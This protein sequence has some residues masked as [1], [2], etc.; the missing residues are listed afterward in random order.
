MSLSIGPGINIVGSVIITPAIGTTIP[1][2]PIIGIAL[3]NVPTSANVPYTAPSDN[4]GSTILKYIATS[5]PGGLTGTLNQAGSGTITV[6]GLTPAT[7]Y[8]FRVTATNSI[9]ISSPSLPSNI[10]STPGAGPLNTVAP[11]VTGTATVG[12]T[13]STDNGTWT[14]TP[15]IVFTYQWQRNSA[16][17]SSATNNTYVLVDADAENPIRCVVTGTNSAGTNLANSNAT[18]NVSPIAPGAPTIGTA[19][20]IT[21]SATVDFT[22]PVNNGGS[23]ILSYTA[24]SSPGGLTGTV[25]QSGSGTITVTGLTIDTS[26]TFTVTATNIIGTGSPSSASNSIT[27]YSSPSNT[28]AP[29]VSGTATVGQT[30]STTNGTWLGSAPITFTYQWQ[31]SDTNIGGA[32]SSTYIL[33]AADAEN[34]IRCV[35]T[36]TNIYGNA[37][38]NSNATSNVAAIVPGAPTIGTATP[39][40]LTTATVAFTA[41]ASNGG[42]TILSY[43]ATSSPSG[44]TSTLTQAGSGIITVTGL[45]TGTSYTFTVTATNAIGTSSPSAS[46]NS[47]TTFTVPVNTVAPAISGTQSYESVLSCSTGTWT[48]TP[49]PTFTYQWQRNGGNIS[50]ATSNTYTLTSFDVFTIISCI[51]TGTNP[52]GTSSANSNNTSSI[53]PIAPGSPTSITAFTNGSAGAYV[54]FTAPTNNGGTAI[55]SYTATS[56]PGGITG[57]VNQSVSGTITVTGLTSATSYTFTVTATN[58]AGTSSPSSASNSITTNN[59]PPNAPTI[60]TATATSDQT[61]NVAYTA[62]AFN[63]GATIISYTATSNPG[64]VTGTLT[65]AGSGTISMTRLVPSTSYTFTVTATNNVGTGSPSA[66][67]NSITTSTAPAGPKKAIFGFGQTGAST[68]VSLTN[69]I[70]YYGIVASDTTGV[71]SARSQLAATGYG[72]TGQAMFAYGGQSTTGYSYSNLISAVGVVATNTSI[73]GTARQQLAAAMYGVD[74][75]VFGYGIVGTGL[76]YTAVTNKVSNLG[77]IATDTTGV[78]TIRGYL[79]AA[80]YGT[81]KAIFGYGQISNFPNTATSISNKVSNTGVVAANTTG[82]GTIRYGL[83]AAGYGGD[84]AIFGF[85]YDGTQR[86]SKTNLVS[87]TGVIAT[88]TTNAASVTLRYYLAAAGYGGDKA[89]F[90]FG[91]AVGTYVG[92]T[93]LV[94]NTGVV[95]SDVSGIGTSRNNLAAASYS[96]TV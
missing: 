78:G 74:K 77:V 73:V 92:M 14:G 67:S 55:S 46:S 84:K 22:A 87:N 30:L 4:G 63:G 35:V 19:T 68:Y 89:I 59:G 52:Y 96:T 20:A 27:A 10:I 71:G 90:G 26:Y 47:I 25:T 66:A 6:D 45:T 88:D 86:Y 51:V 29:V 11:L 44:I 53:Q 15:T 36:G 40:S 2:N 83:A 41:P 95:A 75:A 60:G 76:T 43:T 64:N 17:I 48:G 24:T 9:G 93:N 3:S 38:A 34:P 18:S 54:E 57:T 91:F 56:S 28:V 31:R 8:S 5:N 81:D 21:T 32:T 69:L 80:G 79:A 61:A 33:V 42:S 58:S 62:P 85:G 50:L 16:N 72:S 49:T 1:N 70:S 37:S 65:Q 23:T 94:S 13:L 7:S 82:V 12:Q 39:T